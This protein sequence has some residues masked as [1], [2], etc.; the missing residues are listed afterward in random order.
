MCKGVS[1]SHAQAFVAQ[2]NPIGIKDGL[3]MSIERNSSDAVMASTGFIDIPRVIG[4]ISG[5][6]GREEAEGIN[7]LPV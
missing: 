4:S 2:G 7:G 3:G 5:D 6:M 1:G